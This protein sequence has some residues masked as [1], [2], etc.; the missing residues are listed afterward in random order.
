MNTDVV[1]RVIAP[2]LKEISAAVGERFSLSL[3]PLEIDT[4]QFDGSG[5]LHIEGF[6]A[7]SPSHRAL[8]FE[9]VEDQLY[10]IAVWVKP[11]DLEKPDFRMDLSA[12]DPSAQVDLIA[13]VLNGN[14]FEIQEAFESIQK[15]PHL[16]EAATEEVD[17]YLSSIGS[18]AF[19][20]KISQLYRSY[21]SWAQAKGRKVISDARFRGLTNEW[22]MSHN[23]KGQVAGGIKIMSRAQDKENISVED[24]ERQAFEKDIM[25]NEVLYTAN[26]M[27]NVLR[28][29]AQDDPGI[30]SVFLCGG[31][32]LGKAQP[33]H[34]KIL[35]PTGW[36]TM[37]EIQVGDEI[38]TP[39]G[40]TTRVIDKFPQGVKEIFE[41]TLRDGSKA[42][43]CKEHLWKVKDGKNFKVQELGSFMERA[44]I[45]ANSTKK[46]Y[47]LPLCK[48][49]EFEKKSL[50]IDP[51]ILGLL[52]GDGFLQTAVGFC[53]IDEELKVAIESWA[54]TENCKLS[55][56]SST[57]YVIVSQQA[58]KD[59]KRETN[60]VNKLIQDLGLFGTDSYTKFIPKEY[61]LSSIEDRMKLLRG[62]LDTD[63]YVNDT[64]D[65]VQFGTSSPQLAKD[66]RELI[67]SLGGYCY[68]K[69][70]LPAY[71]SEKYREKRV[72]ENSH[73]CFTINLSKQLGNPFQLQRKSKRYEKNTGKQKH[74]TS[75]IVSIEYIG[76]FEASCIMI[77]DPDHLYVTDDYVVTHNSFTVKKVFKE[78]KV[79]DTKVVYRSGSIAGFTGLLQLLW[80]YRK[81]RILILDDNDTILNLPKA[82]NILKA[83][84]NSKPEDRVISY[85][86]LRK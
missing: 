79:W 59:N 23:R 6:Y 66:F 7:F 37:G 11:E 33:H 27:E 43:S 57:D 15:F 2:L 4:T 50:P 47:S 48:P 42:Q 67:K 54:K 56:R 35:T 31:A 28:R 21:F 78:E 38:L 52:L 8:R 13:D 80:D 76:D 86:K 65:T 26:M 1:E 32:G 60:G 61:L 74:E 70:Y 58:Q 73:T 69:E 51:Y 14:G 24:K 9:I 25:E 18:E 72:S 82:A 19:E 34:S 12:T 17:A 64:G 62:L 45:A 81:D 40:R 44:R 5:N 10:S 36:T 53:T 3:M 46:S 84:L 63:G 22:L 75:S 49:I 55:S 85:T 83:A 77:A 39:S 71:Y 29:V 41:I 20:K 30:V 16:H 68:Q